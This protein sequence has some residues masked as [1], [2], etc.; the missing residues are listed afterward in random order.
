MQSHDQK[1]KG[2]EDDWPPRSQSFDPFSQE[3][4]LL[5]NAKDVVKDEKG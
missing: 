2:Y 1:T 5:P 3:T 4:Q